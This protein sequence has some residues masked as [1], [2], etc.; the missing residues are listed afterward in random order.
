M[1]VFIPIRGRGG[2]LRT[3]ALRF[4]DTSKAEADWEQLARVL[5]DH[6]IMPAVRVGILVAAG[7]NLRPMVQV[8]YYFSDCSIDQADSQSSQLR[9]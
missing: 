2:L 1:L 5:S 8:S 9:R 7:S 4:F 6:V 3:G